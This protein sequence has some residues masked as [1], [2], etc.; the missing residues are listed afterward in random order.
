M[1]RPEDNA[2]P[3]DTRSAYFPFGILHP[4]KFHVN[5]CEAKTPIIAPSLSNCNTGIPTG[6]MCP[7]PARSHQY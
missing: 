1:H 7:S 4:A 5:Q 6:K 3:T 2:K